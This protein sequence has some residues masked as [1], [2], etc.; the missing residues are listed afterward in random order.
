MTSIR[1]AS[2]QEAIFQG[3]DGTIRVTVPCN[4]GVVGEA[5][6]RL[7]RG[8]ATIVERFPTVRQYVLQFQNLAA[9]R[10][11]VRPTRGRWRTPR[12]PR[13]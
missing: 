4:A 13:R 2:R 9:R 7:M 11:M 6:V 5:Q 10:V 1:L 8:D 12:A 3:E